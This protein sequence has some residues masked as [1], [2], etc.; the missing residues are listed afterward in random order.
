M[1]TLH[2]AEVLLSL[3]FILGGGSTLLAPEHRAAQI[4]RL[5]FPLARVAVRINGLAMVVG[6]LLLALGLWA[7]IVAW[8]LIALLIPTTIFGHAFWLEAGPKR[9]DQLSHFVKNLGL[10]GGLLLVTLLPR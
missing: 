2:L 6:G 8:V 7:Q 10:L 3:I 5:H 4:A 1:V 9:Q